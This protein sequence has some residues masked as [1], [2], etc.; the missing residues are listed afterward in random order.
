MLADRSGLRDDLVHV[1]EDKDMADNVLTMAFFSLLGSSSFSHLASEQRTTWFPADSPIES[2]DASRLTASI[3]EDAKQALFRCRKAR[4]DAT[5]W[6]GIDSTS[7]THYGKGLADSK[8]GKN[9]EHDHADQVNVL[10]LYDITDGSP[11]YYR[12]MPGNMPDTRSMRVTLDEF[13]ANGF[14]NVNL[15]RDRGYVSE[16]V[17]Q[18][19]TPV[20]HDGED[21]RRADCQGHTR[22]RLR[23]D[24]QP[25]ALDRQA[26]RFRKGS[27]L[28]VQSN[29]Q[30]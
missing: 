15:V 19:E 2:W 16:E 6:L 14:G 1:F 25:S 29:R 21:W 9:K 13:M 10:V 30:R 4:T 5:S 27:G 20:C 12:Q 26:W 8:R 11:V 22:N 23:G 28:Q 17:G 18:G 7:F 3:T 24:D